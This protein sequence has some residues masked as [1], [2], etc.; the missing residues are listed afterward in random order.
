MPVAIP[1][2]IGG[3][4]LLLLGG[5]GLALRAKAKRAAPPIVPVPPSPPPASN[6]IPASPFVATANLPPVKNPDG[7]ER[8]PGTP[9]I[10][11]TTEDAQKIVAEANRLGISVH[12]LLARQQ[13]LLPST[14]VDAPQVVGKRGIVTTSDPSPRGDLIIRTAPNDAASLIPGGGADKGGTVTVI[15]DVDATWAEIDWAGG[16]RPAGRGFAKKRFIKLVG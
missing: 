16:V 4:V 10:S 8:V 11:A 6:V 13:G 15:R 9:F 12:E 1:L 5:T 7:S 2:A 3:G 14:V